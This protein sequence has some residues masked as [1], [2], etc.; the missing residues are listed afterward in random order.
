[1]VPSARGESRSLASDDVLHH[2]EALKEAGFKE[3]VLTGI[4]LGAYGLD[5]KPAT[6]LDDLLERIG[7]EKP[8]GRI[9]LSSIEPH[10]VTDRL[11]STLAGSEVLCSHL[12]IPLQSGDNEIL[13]D[14]HRPYSSHYFE[15]LI[16]RITSK[17]PHCG[18]GLDVMV[19]FPGEDEHRFNRTYRLIEELPVSY[20]HVFPFS[21]RP[22]TTAADLPDQV[23]AKAKKERARLLREL[24]QRKRE[25][26]YSRFVGSN[27]AV[28]IE[29]TRDRKTGLIK[30][31]SP[32]YIPVLV[33]GSDEW[34]NE[35]IEVTVTGVKEG[36]VY[37]TASGR[38][39]R[40]A[41]G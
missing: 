15:K 1:V 23:A 26:F 14:M 33:D 34:K 21:K 6:T 19:G 41:T 4:H 2:L 3:V 39:A 36:R 32:N 16:E 13:K 30:G 40:K 5:L 29:D 28:L 20:L 17:I 37:G 35:E 27:L 31:F 24:G 8:L 25:G 9:R 7:R 11:L 10:E 18:I 38:V 22:G 12:H